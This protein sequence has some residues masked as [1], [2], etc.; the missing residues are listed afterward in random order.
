MQWSCD[1]YRR[2]L[3]EV[4][5]E[6]RRK[7]Y[8]PPR[9]AVKEDPRWQD[10]RGYRTVPDIAVDRTKEDKWRDELRR[11]ITDPTS[12]NC[13]FVNAVV[14]NGEYCNAFAAAV[15]TTSLVEEGGGAPYNIST[16]RS[17]ELPGKSGLTN[18][19]CSSVQPMDIVRFVADNCEMPVTVVGCDF[20]HL[21]TTGSRTFFDGFCRFG[22]VSPKTTHGT[23][24]VESCR[25]CLPTRRRAYFVVEDGLTLYCQSHAR[26]SLRCGERMLLYKP[27]LVSLRINHA[28]VWLAVVERPIETPLVYADLPDTRVADTTLVH[29]DG[30]LVVRA[31]RDW[32]MP[33]DGDDGTPSPSD[34]V[35][36]MQYLCARPLARHKLCPRSQDM[37][38]RTSI[39]KVQ[40]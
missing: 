19:R 36:A 29:D 34:I 27:T 20:D 37:G 5:E 25:L 32:D 40:S 1:E 3:V 39:N 12:R 30:V 8:F 31:A 21:V 38:F 6:D 18:W 4:D 16:G 13:L 35:R 10:L 28:R 15:T 17:D 23:D 11:R 2:H 14:V 24:G 9:P 26:Q 7:R 33:W 22:K